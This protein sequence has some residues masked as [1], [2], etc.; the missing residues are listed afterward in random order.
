MSIDEDPTQPKLSAEE[1]KRVKELL[2]K[3][4][5][6]IKQLDEGIQKAQ[7]RSEKGIY[8]LEL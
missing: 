8:N 3:D 5:K 7:Q 4:S 2:D 1:I 6:E